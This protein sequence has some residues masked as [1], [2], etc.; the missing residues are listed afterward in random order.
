MSRRKALGFQIWKMLSDLLIIFDIR[1]LIHNVPIVL[2][3]SVTDAIG[4]QARYEKIKL[5]DFFINGFRILSVIDIW[6]SPVYHP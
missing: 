4:P 5:L 3:A 2:V 6:N 1:E